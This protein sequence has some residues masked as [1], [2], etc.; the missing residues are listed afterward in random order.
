MRKRKQSL[1]CWA[2]EILA[3]H[4]GKSLYFLNIGQITVFV[5]WKNFFWGGIPARLNNQDILLNVPKK[6]Q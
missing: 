3:H 2:S 6:L 4:A 1:L 5:F